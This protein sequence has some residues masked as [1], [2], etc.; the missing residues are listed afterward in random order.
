MMGDQR[1]VGT[2]TAYDLLHG[3]FGSGSA[4]FAQPATW[5]VRALPSTCLP[6]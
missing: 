4:P 3:A 6:P 1:P 2:S 5:I